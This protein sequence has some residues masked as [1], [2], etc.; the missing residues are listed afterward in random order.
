MILNIILHIG[1]KIKYER[2]LI[3]KFFSLNFCS[4]SLNLQTNAIIMETMPHHKVVEQ[5]RV[6]MLSL[7]QEVNEKIKS[8]S[9]SRII[10]LKIKVFLLPAIYIALYLSVLLH[11]PIAWSL[12]W[13]YSLMGIM[14]VVIFVNLIHEA[15]HGNIFKTKKLNLYTYYLF[16]LLGA[17]SYIW[18]QRHLNLHHRFPNT[19]GWD[20]DIE[21]K[22]LIS[23]FP[24]ESIKKYH[25]FQHIYVFLLYPL[26]MLNW[27]FVRDFK[28]FFSNER[29]IRKTTSIPA[30]EYVKLFLFKIFYLYTIVFLPILV[31]GYTLLETTLGLVILT[32]TGSVFALLVL[33][34][35]HVNIVNQFPVPENSGEISHSWFRHQFITTND[36]ENT[37][38]FIKN[39]FGNFNYHLAH[40][41]FPQISSVYAPEVTK[42]V[43]KFSQANQLPYRS[44]PL[45]EALIKHYQLIRT[46]ALHTIDI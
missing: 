4:L 34:T 41:L 42:I 19:N 14:V 6:L 38:W 35:P 44:F 25:R 5:D 16:D 15:C 20:A 7:F 28:D 8:L 2:I 11:N 33:L 23:I 32:T 40:H 10:T 29:I 43:K 3:Q 37:N 18:K 9:K 22:G 36:V 26:F 30:V 17:N 1:K 21:Q 13:H 27:L 39:I 24:N 12:Y 46:R 45:S 31:S